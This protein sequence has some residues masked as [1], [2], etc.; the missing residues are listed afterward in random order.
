MRKTSARLADGREIIYFDESDAQRELR[1]PRDPAPP[2]TASELRFDPL[3]EEWVVLAAHRQGRTHLPATAECP[4]CPSGGGRQTEI[5]A[6]SYDVVAFENRFPALA[7]GDPPY[8]GTEELPVPRRAG[9]GRCEV[10]CFA[11]DHDASFVDLSPRRVRTIVD[12]WADRTRELSELPGVEQVFCFENRGPEIGVTLHHPHGQIYAYSFRTPRTRRTLD[13]AQRYRERTGRD[14]FADDLR[15]E[16]NAGVRV[17]RRSEHWTAFVPAA[18][19]WPVELRI[20]PNRRVAD[21]PE[22]TDAERDDFSLLYLDILGRLDR[23]F[24]APL[25]YVAAWHQAPVRT[26]RDLAYLH[27][28]LFSVRR[29]PGKLKYLA[30]SEAAMGVF[31]NDVLPETTAQRLREAAP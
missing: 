29:A 3:L 30:G 16:R 24:D 10:L 11:A 26:Q 23:L 4:L 7:F 27:L 5:P 15:A 25:P 31:V 20:Y 21:L 12:V 6:S 19:R 1:D 2:P 9:E 8:D 14:L 28:E 17:V 13:S 22:L 18:A